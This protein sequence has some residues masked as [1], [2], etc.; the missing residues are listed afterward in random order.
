MQ[1][2]DNKWLEMKLGEII[3]RFFSDLEI[4]NSISIHFGRKN[5]RQLGKISKRHH[6]S[7]LS[8]LSN[9]FDTIITLNSRFRDPEIPEFVIEGTIIHEMCHY[10]HGF[11]SPLPQK[12]KY[13]HQGGI[14]KHEMI[15]RGAGD[16]YLNEKKWLKKNWQKHL[17]KN[18]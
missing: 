1:I 17:K 10:A 2:R 7:I 8:R 9:N 6:G 5:E 16:I 18:F 11:S 4:K 3:H 15:Q 13:P 14:I 12:C